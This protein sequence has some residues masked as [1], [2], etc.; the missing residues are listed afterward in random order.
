MVAQQRWWGE[1]KKVLRWEQP[2]PDDATAQI[3]SLRL[4]AEGKETDALP[5]FL[6]RLPNLVYV[7]LPAHLAKTLQ[8]EQLPH[9]VRSLHVRENGGSASIRKSA[10]FT[11]IKAVSSARV[12]L[13]FTPGNFPNIKYLSL[14]FDARKS[15][16]PVL[17]EINTLRY[18]EV[19]PCSDEQTLIGLTKN[20]LTYLR[21]SGGKITSLGGIER[22]ERLRGLWLHD[23]TKLS[24][25]TSLAALEDL[26]ELTIA[27]C[28]QINSAETFLKIR[29]L[30]RLSVLGCGDI[31]VTQIR[32]Q[33]NLLGLEKLDLSG[34]R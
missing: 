30:R 29:N 13:K 26:Q 27:Y 1:A 3:I 5:V 11:N 33:L 20:D 2:L 18:L 8:T 28:P 14:R 22:L 31:W 15:M 9:S 25:I 34:S 19:N 4:C 17:R 32:P 6:R 16:L 12:A 10:S 23:L 21:L 7:E 24:D